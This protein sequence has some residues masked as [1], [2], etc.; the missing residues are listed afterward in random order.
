M[1]HIVICDDDKTTRDQL[2]AYTEQMSNL[3]GKQFQVTC[4]ASGEELLSQ[5]PPDTDILLLDIQMG[6]ISGMDAA[7]S[8]RVRC[9]NLC[10]IFITSQVQYALEGYTVHA[11]GF[12]RKPIRFGS[13][14]QQMADAL[15]MLSMR[16]GCTVTLKTAGETYQLNCNEIYY[17]ESSGHTVT[18]ALQEEKQKYNTDLGLVEEQLRNHGFCRCHKSLLINFRYIQKIGQSDILMCN[19][20]ILPLSRRRRKEFVSAFSQYIGGDL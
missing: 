9:R 3:T 12:L 10:V 17:I 11:F 14:R 7:R 19:G 1:R 8:L 16:Q 13:F 15:T 2:C 18:I 5:F 4:F 6:A 20:E